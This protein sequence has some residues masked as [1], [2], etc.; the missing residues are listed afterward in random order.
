MINTQYFLQ[1]QQAEYLSFNVFYLVNLLFKLFH[2]YKLFQLWHSSG[3][4]A[5]ISTAEYCF[6]YYHIADLSE[7]SFTQN[8]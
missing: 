3:C 4:S 7:L 8:K 5:F 1:I 6:K 2:V